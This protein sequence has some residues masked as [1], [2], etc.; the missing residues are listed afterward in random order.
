MAASYTCRF[1]SNKTWFFVCMW[2]YLLKQEIITWSSCWQKWTHKSSYVFF[3]HIQK[4]ENFDNRWETQLKT[5][6]GEIAFMQNISHV[7]W[8][9]LLSWPSTK[10]R[11]EIFHHCYFASYFKASYSEKNI[12]FLFFGLLSQMIP[13]KMLV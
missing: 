1:I 7:F 2:I 12:H 6:R 4:W 3:P 11:T 5:N 13:N 9:F 10:V 8:S